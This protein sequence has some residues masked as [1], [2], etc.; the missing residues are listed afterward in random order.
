MPTAFVDT[1]ILI[2]AA[3]EGTPIPRKTRIARELL[4]Q[5]DLCI[6]VQVLNEFTVNARHPKKL[7]LSKEQESDWLRQWLRLRVFPLT[8][9]TYLD[10]LRIHLHHRLSHWDSLILSSAINAGCSFL[11]SEDLNAGQEIDSV[12][13][14]NPFGQV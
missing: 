2:Y 9:N 10:A 5:R 13:I 8:V 14:I 7:D 11:Y 6:S 3:D 1:N 4:L 12:R